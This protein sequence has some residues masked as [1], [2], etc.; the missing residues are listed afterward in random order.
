[1]IVACHVVRSEKYDTFNE[2]AVSPK[3]HERTT[4]NDGP[5]NLAALLR[6]IRIVHRRN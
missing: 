2:A 6:I 1:M 5:T 4:Q 3:K